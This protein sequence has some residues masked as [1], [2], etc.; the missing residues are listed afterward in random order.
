MAR[1]GNPNFGKDVPVPDLP[2]R[3][4]L[5]VEKLGLTPEQY[6]SSPELRRW[7]ERRKGSCYIPESLL[8]ELYGRGIQYED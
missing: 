6:S 3:F 8:V 2:T 5:Y 4:E 7:I 1:K